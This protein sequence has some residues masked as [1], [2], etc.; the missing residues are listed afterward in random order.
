MRHFNKAL[1]YENNLPDTER[2]LNGKEV[3][4]VLFLTFAESAFAVF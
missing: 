3:K 4:A 2:L 1:I